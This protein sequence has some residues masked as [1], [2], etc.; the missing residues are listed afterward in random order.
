MTAHPHAAPETFDATRVTAIGAAVA[1]VT[2]VGVGL[3]VSVPLLSLEMERMGVSSTLI[4]INTAISGVACMI[5]VPFMPRV[6]ARIGVVPLLWLC[7]AVGAASLIAFK[8]LYSFTWWFPLRFVFAAVLGTLF[9]LSEYWIT[10]AAPE[11]RRGLV[12]GIYA[13]VLSL[14]FAAGPALLALVGTSGWPPY[15]AGAVLFGLAALPPVFARSLSPDLGEERGRTVASLIV[16]APSATFAA[17]IFGA[18][19]TGGFAL[20]P[21]YGLQLGLDASAAALL[22]SMLALGGVALQVP[23]GMVSDRADRRL[24]LVVIG[25]I[26]ALGALLMPM[27]AQSALAFNAV[28]FVWGGVTGGLYT[29]GLAHLGERFRGADLA[30]ANAAFVVLYNV[31]LVI[32]PTAV[33]AGMDAVPPHGF[34]YSLAAFFGLY[35]AIVAWRMVRLRRA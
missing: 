30:S 29:V 5:V 2:A 10:A 18:V 23:M 31:G 35:V 7:I 27:A 12:M 20:L 28:L 4:G 15:L 16:A 24:V 8:V 6:A 17:L 14:G 3:S 25:I 34:A 22:V 11:H 9:A 21:I 13:S 19:E 32:G 26:G 33:G 1:S